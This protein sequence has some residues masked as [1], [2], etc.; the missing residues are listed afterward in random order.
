MDSNFLNN[1]H[2]TT[3]RKITDRDSIN[4]TDKGLISL[5][6]P[7]IAT[8][9]RTHTKPITIVIHG[10]VPDRTHMKIPTAGVA[11]V[12]I[13]MENMSD[14]YT[15]AHKC[16]REPEPQFQMLLDH[17]QRETRFARQDYINKT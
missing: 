10:L 12:N 15:R 1:I 17:S 13:N 2:E 16:S 7:R 6:G 3:G 11:T 5:A 9:T 4:R 14:P 8:T